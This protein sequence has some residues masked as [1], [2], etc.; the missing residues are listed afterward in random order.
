[1]DKLS[2]FFIGC[3]SPEGFTSFLD[4]LY[5]PYNNGY[6]YIIKGGPGTG[7]STLMKKIYSILNA[8]GIQGECIFCS[9]DPDSLDAFIIPELHCCIADGTNP[10]ALEP[11]YY[12]VCEEFINLGEYLDKE[13]L[14][15]RKE[16]IIEA[17]DLNKSEHQKC[18]NLLQGAALSQN[19]IKKIL[20]PLTDVYSLKETVRKII[21]K[22]FKH[23]KA[24]K[25]KELHRFISAPTSKGMYF[26]RDEVLKLCD[27][28]YILEDNFYT[29]APMLLSLIREYA[30][31]LG[32]NIISSPN[33]LSDKK[34]L[35]HILIPD[36]KLGFLTSSKINPIQIDN[37]KTIKSINYTDRERLQKSINKVHFYLKARDEFI[38]E[39][40][41]ALKSSK[42]SHDRL[43][44][45]YISA[46][47]FS[48]MDSLALDISNKMLKFLN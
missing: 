29:F 2:G 10:H 6:A 26:N 24:K 41:K 39:A 47:D 30:L 28:F 31:D 5:N 25:G 18:K 45:L 19:E 42:I 1:M 17:A 35:E 34:D 11:K 9:S 48:H 40:L 7:K 3:S 22:E 38:S 27:R 8:K 32:F 12:G 33:P 15:K 44:S 46:M 20:I 43:E 36:L 23:P 14:L 4:E 13:E 21:E 37:S 16:N